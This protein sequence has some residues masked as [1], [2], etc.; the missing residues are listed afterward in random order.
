ML[1]IF[2][3]KY[4]TFV[5]ILLLFVFGI[6]GAEA[7]EKTVATEVYKTTVI[8][9]DNILYKQL[10]QV[11]NSNKVLVD[12]IKLIYP[13]GEP[14]F[15]RFKE[16]EWILTS[17][18][19]A[20]V[21]LVL[22]KT[23]PPEV[24]TL[25]GTYGTQNGT[26]QLHVA[27]TGAHGLKITMDG[28][29]QPSNS[30]FRMDGIF[31]ASVRD[32]R[33]VEQIALHLGQNNDLSANNWG[34]STIDDVRKLMALKQSAHE[35]KRLLSEP[36]WIGGVPVQTSFD[37][38]LKVKLDNIELKPM[39]GE[40]LLSKKEGLA[41]PT[42]SLS[43]EGSIVP[44]WSEWTT[45]PELEP[46]KTK[47]PCVK[48]TTNAGH[49]HI[50][51]TSPPPLGG[52]NWYTR[53]P[54]HPD[55]TALVFVDEGTIDIQL[56]GKEGKIVSGTIN[57]K[58]KVGAGTRPVSTFSAELSGEQQGKN[59]V[60]SIARYVG[61]RPFDGRWNTPKNLKLKIE[62]LSLH[63]QRNKVSGS[64]SGGTIE[65]GVV[66]GSVLNLRWKTP[67][68]DSHKGFLSAAS[69]GLLVGM[70]WNEAKNLSFEPVVAVQL[71]PTS[72][73]NSDASDVF[74]IKNETEAR[75]LS[76]LGY[77][78]S[79]AGKHQE[80]AKILLHVVEYYHA[81]EASLKEAL[82]NDPA[83]YQKLKTDLI[84]QVTP[85]V[86]LIRDVFEAGDYP[87]LIK[88][89][90]M[91]LHVQTELEKSK[92]DQRS[93]REQVETH[94]VN[95]NKHAETMDL[96]KA[97][98]TRGLMLLS[99]S[100]I[101]I[102]LDE[103]SKSA[104]IKITGV[105][106]DM[107]ASRANVAMGDMLVAIN[108][109]S[110]EGMSTEQAS[111]TLRG[112][113]GSSVSIKL[114][115]GGQY[116]ELKLVRT[117]LINMIPEQREELT[118][119]ISAIRDLVANTSNYC[120]T[121]ASKLNLLSTEVT[122]VQA[123][124]KKVIDR[125][126]EYQ[127][128]AEDQRATAIA[129][130][131]RGLA[132]SPQA[133]N[134]FQR[135]ISLQN[136][137]RNGEMDDE[138]SARMWE[139]D[140]EEDA[141]EKK[142]DVSEIDKGFFRCSI[143]MVNE[144]N[145]MIQIASSRLSSVNQAVEYSSKSPDA[146]KTA[147]MLATI[148]GWLDNWRSRMVTDAAKIESLNLGRDFYADYV[149]VLVDMNL[150]EQA[151][152]AS[153]TARARAF[154]DLL[155]RSHATIIPP[156]NSKV[157]LASLSSTKTM[158]P[159]EIRQLVRDTGITVVEYFVLK[160]TLLTW[161]IM[162]PKLDSKE[163]DIHLLKTQV[164]QQV[165]KD[166]IARLVKTLRPTQKDM[167]ANEKEMTSELKS[168]YDILIAPI[169]NLLPKNSDQVVTIVPHD[170]LFRIPFAALAHSIKDGKIDHYLVEDHALTYTPS[171]AVLNVSRQRK[172]EPVTP[173]SLLAVIKPTL[174]KDD[175][176]KYFTALPFTVE[177]ISK[178]TINFYEP[179]STSILS[180]QKA[181]QQKVLV[182]APSRDVVLFYTHAKA[183]D[184]D[185]LG[186]YI[187]LTNELLTAKTIGNQQLNARLVILAACQT[188]LGEITG[189]GVQ[190][191]ARMFM[192]AGAETVMV[193]LWSVPQDAT[194]E[195]MYAFHQAWRR[196]NHGIAA[197][198]RQAQIQ[199]LKDYPNQVPM[200]A[201][202]IIIGDEQ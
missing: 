190:G 12:D 107:P 147:N 89:L 58:G 4:T 135:F 126:A 139:L 76:N 7:S 97:S 82:K 192:V 30:G 189:D 194:L 60:E 70:T 31:T 146:L 149:Q 21:Q 3:M 84:F 167:D 154:A 142:P 25:K 158:T 52:I 37:V 130:A 13:I 178:A 92:S 28:I 26:T 195:L 129:L 198:L 155:A 35:E 145:L 169:E 175:L 63:Q 40:L 51:I 98:F 83:T 42:V 112:S 41:E 191:L 113:A 79:S 81:R 156:A 123:T 27:G 15:L 85:L 161:V 196:E 78:L 122:D 48:V 73:S 67:T 23:N 108:G 153:E 185:P 134:L 104:G 66:T 109:I 57:S 118:K 65:E 160:D 96:L 100:G 186:S 131:E 176:G 47:D 133:L 159:D 127:K 87:T 88:A 80:A 180:D 141:F 143:T 115:R 86:Q 71:L 9:Q 120:R 10:A 119:S 90:S 59:L 54:D 166:K 93:F 95:L 94:I 199:L 29:L 34:N 106:S 193:S 116:R 150:P 168:L 24:F 46:N 137:S 50:A 114:L 152:Q 22:S 188:G 111:I 68:G 61:T 164:G 64:F 165:L 32:A 75:A 39:K 5:F 200:W 170:N 184:K 102:N 125:L 91:A 182:E 56:K 77:D 53:N 136:M 197:S 140:Q 6:F 162:P 49:I 99:A 117:P 11:S 55:E 202:F 171:L 20:A 163:V 74:F 187:A 1:F 8:E 18:G 181:T 183:I 138:T 44:G 62:K 14:L 201:G 148:A 172:R 124:F 157:P 69:D 110:V 179:K 121:E 43:T 132:K 105:S 101:G 151:L 2:S 33:H 72:K 16:A 45:E 128:S 36:E 17:D 103:N 177:E 38:T 144:F 174:G 173:S 19:I